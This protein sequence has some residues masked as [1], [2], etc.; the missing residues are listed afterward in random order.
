M[1]YFATRW[2]IIMIRKEKKNSTLD[3]GRPNSFGYRFSKTDEIIRE[4]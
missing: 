1:A 4:N 2:H 3:I